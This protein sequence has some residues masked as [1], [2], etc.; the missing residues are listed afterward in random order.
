MRLALKGAAIVAI[1]VVAAVVT[2]FAVVPADVPP[3]AS[4]ELTADEKALEFLSSVVG[5]NVTEYMGRV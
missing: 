4:P 2:V 5:L 3:E 1:V